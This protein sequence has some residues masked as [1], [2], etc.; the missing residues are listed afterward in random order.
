M[1]DGIHRLQRR[2]SARNPSRTARRLRGA[3]RS[4]FGWRLGCRCAL[5]SGPTAPLLLLIVLFIPGLLYSAEVPPEVISAQQSRVTTIQKAMPAVVAI[6]DNEGKGGGSGVMGGEMSQSFFMATVK[7]ALPR[8]A[9][10]R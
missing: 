7:V 3:W 1:I 5:P 8:A 6:F 2:G 4:R 9:W 10:C